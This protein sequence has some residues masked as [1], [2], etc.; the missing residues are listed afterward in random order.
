MLQTKKKRLSQRFQKTI[1][2]ESANQ[3][4][5]ELRKKY[6]INSNVEKQYLVASVFLEGRISV[7]QKKKKNL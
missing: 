6:R 4:V 7:T 2:K 3:G 5:A 1:P